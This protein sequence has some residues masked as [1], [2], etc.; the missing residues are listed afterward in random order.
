MRQEDVSVQKGTDKTET[1]E[2]GGNSPMATADKFREELHQNLI[3]GDGG[4]VHGPDRFD[5][6]PRKEPRDWP[7][8]HEWPRPGDFPPL[9]DAHEKK[10]G[11]EQLPTGDSLV[12]E[13]G[14]Q[15]LFTKSGDH[16]S[17]N[18]DGSNTIK[19]DVQSVKTNSSGSTTVEFKDGTTVSFDS[20]GF[21]ELNRGF[22]NYNFRNPGPTIDYPHIDIERPRKPHQLP[23]I[24]F[25]DSK[26]Q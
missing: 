13:D 20:D 24:L 11:V 1:N 2:K 8:T 16:I 25:E 21:K 18:P 3:S 5:P 19:G 6:I 22:Q 10:D 23:S 26:K 15:T 12:R 7:S 4:C 9:K 17:I 14:K